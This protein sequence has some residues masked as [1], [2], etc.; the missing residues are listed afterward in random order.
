M[1]SVNKPDR[2]AVIGHPV[3]QSKSP[4]I[5]AAFAR[6]TRQNLVYER[7]PAALDAFAATVAQ[8]ARDGGM[9][10][11]VTAPFKVEAFALAQ[12]HSERAAQAGACN[13]LAWRDTHW[14]GDNTDGAGL[15]R[16]LTVN[17]GVALNGRDILILGAGGAARGILGPLLAAAPRRLVVCNRSPQ[18][19]NSLTL[20]FAANGPIYASAPAELAG[21]RFDVVVNATSAGLSAGQDHA[22]IS[23]PWPPTIFAPGAIAYDLTYAD[24]PTTFMRWAQANGAARVTDGLG[25]LIE[26]ASES[27]FLWRGVRPD[28]APVFPLLRA[29]WGRRNVPGPVASER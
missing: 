1:S 20:L 8:F 17:L 12:Q 19:A 2:Y 16:E 4:A 9:G 24:E 6:Q 18:R 13:T 10:L 26:Q 27:F 11:N 5:H 15:L 23:L 22:A 28:T 7:L 14:F 21:A 3:A 29:N 25:M